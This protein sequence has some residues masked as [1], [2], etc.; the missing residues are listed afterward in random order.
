MTVRFDSPLFVL[1]MANNHMGDIDHG[2]RVV[3]E[4]AEVC[5]AFPFQL[6]FKMQYRHLDSLIHPDYVGRNDIKYIKR[7]SETRLSREET[8][9]LVAEIKAQGFV[10]MCTPF[11]EA[12]VDLILEDGFDILKIASCSFTD[13]ALTQPP[14]ASA[15]VM[16][17]W[18]SAPVGPWPTGR[19]TERRNRRL[20][21][22][23]PASSWCRRAPRSTPPSTRAFIGWWKTAPSTR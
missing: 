5:K 9:R 10:A 4:F 6:A 1:E 21:A 17:R 3:R 12:S 23:S 18:P 11:D 20:P 8:R 16:T 13:C 7:F 2:I 22:V 14:V 19:A 15:L